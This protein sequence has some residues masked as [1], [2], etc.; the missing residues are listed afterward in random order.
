MAKMGMEIQ[1]ILGDSVTMQKSI[2]KKSEQLQRVHMEVEEAVFKVASTASGA[3]SETGKRT[4]KAVAFLHEKIADIVR[5][6][7]EIGAERT[8][9]RYVGRL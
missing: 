7:E 9:Q 8:R 5:C 6:V 1:K 2:N 3:A 4:Y